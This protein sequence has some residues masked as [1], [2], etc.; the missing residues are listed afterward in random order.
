MIGC[1]DLLVST[2]QFDTLATLFSQRVS[3]LFS[4]QI[5]FVSSM[6]CG[7]SETSQHCRLPNM[8]TSKF[9]EAPF[10][11]TAAT[12]TSYLVYKDIVHADR[13]YFPQQ[14]FKLLLLITFVSIVL[15]FVHK[16]FC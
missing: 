8:M 3:T 5:S 9:Q 1:P 16:M 12:A 2:D 4:V 13:H 7:L 10:G 11:Y 15:S 6:L 14:V